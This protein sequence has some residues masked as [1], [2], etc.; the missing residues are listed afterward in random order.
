[1]NRTLLCGLVLVATVFGACAQQKKGTKKTKT[2]TTTQTAKN[3]TDIAS[4]EIHRTN[5]YG[6]CP[7]YRLI[8]TETGKA[9]YVGRRHAEHQGTY[10]G[11]VDAKPVAK[12]FSEFKRY[13]VD[14]CSEKYKNAIPDMAGL[15]YTIIYKNGREQLIQNANSPF[16][17]AFLKGLADQLDKIAPLDVTAWKKTES[18]SENTN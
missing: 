6:R 16:A 2:Q 9:T 13:K 4:I 17:P 7:D 15:E 18:W 12:L 3:T 14:T 11:Q 8:V 10:E 5:C 1:M